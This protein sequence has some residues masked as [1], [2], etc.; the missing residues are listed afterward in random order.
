MM[1]TAFRLFGVV[2]S[3]FVVSLGGKKK[4]AIYD[5]F[6]GHNENILKNNGKN[7]VLGIDF[8]LLSSL[9]SR[10]ALTARSAFVLSFSL[11]LLETLQDYVLW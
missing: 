4:G 10:V 6:L 8:P 5:I 7:P 11:N 2:N 1:F 9:S 3:L